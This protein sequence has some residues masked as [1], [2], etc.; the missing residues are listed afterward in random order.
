[1]KILWSRVIY[2]RYIIRFGKSL[3]IDYWILKNKVWQEK[4]ISGKEKKTY[5]PQK[6]KNPK[7]SSVCDN[8]KHFFIPLQQLELFKSNYIFKSYLNYDCCMFLFPLFFFTLYVLF[9]VFFCCIACLKSVQWFKNNNISIE[10]LLTLINK[11]ET[12]ISAE[13][14]VFFARLRVRD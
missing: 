1:M 8:F 9:S 2:H 13:K 4:K 6:K 5:L 12:K 10:S 11:K 3:L 7:F 14:C